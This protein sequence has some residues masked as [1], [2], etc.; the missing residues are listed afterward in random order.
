MNQVNKLRSAVSITGVLVSLLAGWCAWSLVLRLTN[1][2]EDAGFYSVLLG[3]LTGAAF[4]RWVWDPL[5]QML[6]RRS[7]R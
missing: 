3:L 5:L 7:R 1:N 6:E 4:M 2:G